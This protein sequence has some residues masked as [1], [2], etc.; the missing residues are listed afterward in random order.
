MSTEHTSTRK[1]DP[2]EFR[3]YV[4]P[5]E[6]EDAMV[7]YKWRNDEGYL[8]G[9]DSMKRFVSSE[10]EKRWMEQAVRDHEELREIR[11]GIVLRETG[12][13]I[14]IVHLSDIDW[15]NGHATSGS[16]IGEA[17]HRGKGYVT[18]AR[19]L[20]LRYAFLELGL[21]CISTRILETNTASIRSIERF[22]YLKEGVMRRRIYKE[23]A[24]R[25]LIIYSMLRE[26]FLEKHLPETEKEQP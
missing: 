8:S 15:I 1:P 21:Q 2:Q 10:T 23:G 20:L 18:E 25:D 3:I 14:G 12:D 16:L 11:F 26:E 13:L 9:V 19:H 17:R 4:R 6:P 5:L 7:T 22:G 24:Y